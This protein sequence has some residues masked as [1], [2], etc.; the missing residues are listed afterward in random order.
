MF[1]YQF[2]HFPLPSSTADGKILGEASAGANNNGWA[3]TLRRGGPEHVASMEILQAF[4]KTH[5]VSL[6]HVFWT[7]GMLKPILT[8]FKH[9]FIEDWGYIHIYIYR[10]RDIIFGGT[11]IVK[12]VV[13]QLP[14]GHWVLH[15]YFLCHDVSCS[16][17]FSPRDE[18]NAHNKILFRNFDFAIPVIPVLC[19]SPNCCG[20]KK[21]PSLWGSGGVCS[22]RFMMIHDLTLKWIRNYAWVYLVHQT[23]YSVWFII[24]GYL[25][26]VDLVRRRVVFMFVSMFM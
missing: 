7:M 18:S 20:K 19:S 4:Q 14:S 3:F 8:I 24:Y 15:W 17:V 26:L 22:W 12:S 6:E 10:E 1:E 5:Q 16:R 21:V 9:R 23:M 2:G 11:P 13:F 25:N